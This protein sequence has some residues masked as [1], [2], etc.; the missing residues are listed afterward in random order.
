MA[1]LIDREQAIN[2]V[3]GY[4]VEYCGAAFDEDMQKGLEAKFNRLPSLST[5]SIGFC[6][7][8]KYRE[9]NGYCN[10]H[11]FYCDE[12]DYC[13]RWERMCGADMRGEHDE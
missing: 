11:K 4:L 12:F 3:L 9:E 1:D 2:T 7:W 13:S 5:P 8:C 6:A 10:E